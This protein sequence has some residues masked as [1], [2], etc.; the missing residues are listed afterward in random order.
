MVF[1]YVMIN[2]VSKEEKSRIP[3]LYIIIIFLLHKASQEN[4]LTWKA[5]EVTVLHIRSKYLKKIFF[6]YTVIKT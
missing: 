4:F 2:K 1:I 3:A 6:N 5:S